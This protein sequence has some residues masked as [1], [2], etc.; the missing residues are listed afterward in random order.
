MTDGFFGNKD[1]FL[2][3]GIFAGLFVLVALAYLFADNELGPLS[4]KIEG[5]VCKPHNSKCANAIRIFVEGEGIWQKVTDGCEKTPQGECSGTC[6]WCEPSN[7]K[8]RYCA[9]MIEYSGYCVVDI[10]NTLMSCGPSRPHECLENGGGHGISGCCP[11]EDKNIEPE[12]NCD[13]IATC[14]TSNTE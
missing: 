1:F 2:V 13:K 6:Y 3:V 10:P 7:D 12:G 5:F 9:E 4:K 14:F 8:G 11:D